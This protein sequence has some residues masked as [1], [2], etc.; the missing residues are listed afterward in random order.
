MAH[1]TDALQLILGK[2]VVDKTG[3]SE[4]Y[5]FEV[6]WQN[7][8]L[9]PVTS[10]FRDRF[11]LDLTPARVEMETLVIDHARR[12]PALFLLAQAGRL[13]RFAPAFVR[14]GVSSALMID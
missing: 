9:E 1:I 2:P 11:G 4:R 12:D 13:T 6:T 8:P 14:N 10:A 3:L 5:D 7:P